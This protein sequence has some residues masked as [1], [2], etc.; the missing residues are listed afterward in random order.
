MFWSTQRATM[1]S[2]NTS[3]RIAIWKAWPLTSDCIDKL[4]LARWRTSSV[5]LSLA[6]QCNIT[7]KHELCLVIRDLRILPTFER[8]LS[9]INAFPKHA[10]LLWYLKAIS[11]DRS[12]ALP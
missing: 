1:I 10:S 5:H 8:G 12:C 11:D 6:A 3:D 9:E 2:C 4:N 7:D